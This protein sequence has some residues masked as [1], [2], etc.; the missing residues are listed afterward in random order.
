MTSPVLEL[1]DRSPAT[2]D[3]AGRRSWF[4]DVTGSLQGAPAEWTAAAGPIEDRSLGKDRAWVLLSWV[5]DA[6]SLIGRDRRPELVET[7][8]FAMSLLEASPLDRRD[9]MVVA[10]LVRRATTLSDLDF[11]MLARR[12][13]DR[14][15]LL[16]ARCRTWLLAITDATPST[17]EETGSGATFAFRRKPA[18][19]DPVA[20]ERKL[21]RRPDAS[22]GQG[23]R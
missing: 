13:C 20:L 5:E 4:D 22:G 16:G 6:A 15:G 8:A 12:G 11:A 3:G 10:M 23:D 7:A 21:T 19:F 2:T 1:L 17:H 18:G 9:V 14:A